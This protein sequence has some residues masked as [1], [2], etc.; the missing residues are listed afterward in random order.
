MKTTSFKSIA[1]QVG[2]SLIGVLPEKPRNQKEEDL[3]KRDSIAV[4]VSNC[5]GREDQSTDRIDEET[6]LQINNVFASAPEGK[7]T[8]RLTLMERVLA[9]RSRKA[10]RRDLNDGAEVRNQACSSI[11]SESVKRDDPSTISGRSR[12]SRSISVVR[13]DDV[14]FANSAYS[15]YSAYWETTGSSDYFI[16]DDFDEELT[17]A[18]VIDALRELMGFDAAARDDLVYVAS[19]DST[20]SE[21]SGSDIEDDDGDSVARFHRSVPTAGVEI[22]N[23][24]LTKSKAIDSSG[25]DEK[26]K[27]LDSEVRT[28]PGPEISRMST[29][30]NRT[31]RDEEERSLCVEAPVTELTRLDGWCPLQN[32][33]KESDDIATDVVGSL[34]HTG[35]TAHQTTTADPDEPA[36]TGDEV[37]PAEL[38]TPQKLGKIVDPDEAT[39]IGE[40]ILYTQLPTPQNEQ[41]KVDPEEATSA[42]KEALYT[43]L[44]IP[45]NLEKKV[46]LDEATS[47]GEEVLYEA[48][49]MPQKL[50]RTF[51]LDD[52]TSA[53]EEVLYAK[54]PA[55]RKLQ[56][57]FD[58]DDATS[59]GE[60]VLYT[61]LPT[62]HTLKKKWVPSSGRE[63]AS[64]A[65]PAVDQTSLLRTPG[66]V[67]CLMI[68]VMKKMAAKEI[69]A[70]EETK[71]NRPL[72]TTKLIS[73]KVAAEN[74]ALK[75]KAHV[76]PKPLISN[77][78]AAKDT[79]T[80][81]IPVTPK[82]S[83]CNEITTK[84]GKNTDQAQVPRKPLISF[85]ITGREDITA[86]Q[87]RSTTKAFVSKEIT[88]DEDTPKGQPHAATKALISYKIATEEGTAKGAAQ[89]KKAITNKEKD[90][91]TNL[92]APIAIKHTGTS[93][94]APTSAE[95]PFPNIC[96]LGEFVSTWM[97]S[98]PTCMH[99]KKT[100]NFLDARSEAFAGAE[101]AKV[102]G[103]VHATCEEEYKRLRTKF[104]KVVR[105]I[106]LFGIL[107]KKRAKEIRAKKARKHRANAR[108]G[109]NQSKAAR[110]IGKFLDRLQPGGK[111]DA[112]R[113]ISKWEARSVAPL[114]GNATPRSTI[115]SIP[116]DKPMAF[117]PCA[118]SVKRP[119]AVHLHPPNSTKGPKGEVTPVRVSPVTRREQSKTPSSQPQR[120]RKLALKP[121]AQHVKRSAAGGDDEEIVVCPRG[122]PARQL[123]RK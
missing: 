54:L 121:T 36:S 17:T 24:Q 5:D 76:T 63:E 42:S 19:E 120:S 98:G 51:D 90:Q 62:P 70:T 48:L 59:A 82:P 105:Q 14:Y 73:N 29:A 112:P 45:Q 91:V 4:E 44:P 23:S 18:T 1:N 25:F 41:N 53:G 11:A 22:A 60:E 28:D 92:V 69:V 72:R 100:F 6:N 108:E 86:G 110:S 111:H 75:Q 95:T 85:E 68:S 8:R 97:N 71:A 115:A 35:H 87:A 39:S 30:V 38:P 79:T 74:E 34:S 10:E 83:I 61:D 16:D 31:Q 107:R 56:S 7:S 40:E 47:T 96:S 43:T 89:T 9:E 26:K 78:F 88:T 12:D 116:E 66:R 58:L 65:E 49:P 52:S 99:C 101:R 106:N 15:A 94:K 102:K 119:N 109:K 113:R 32:E 27:V 50:G 55:P 2:K 64:G 67:K 33:T 84:K 77:K 80:D 57:K 46:D 13:E 93:L 20:T 117:T 123:D 3:V 103:E 114:R 118:N 104:D 122:G 81:L 37:L 21:Y